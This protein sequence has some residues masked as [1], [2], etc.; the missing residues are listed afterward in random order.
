M[1]LLI[2]VIMNL[3][4]INIT[5]ASAALDL[6]LTGKINDYTSNLFLRIDSNAGSGIDV[7]DMY[8]RET[9]S[10]YSSFSSSVAG[11]SLSIDS[12]ASNPR[13]LNLT[14]SVSPAQTGTFNLSWNSSAINTGSYVVTLKYYGDNSTYTTQVG[15]NVDMSAQ[16]SYT[17]DITGESD[18]YVRIIVEDY[19][20]PTA[21]PVSP[22]GGGGGAAPAVAGK[23]FEILSDKKM[24][25]YMVIDQNKEQTIVLKNPTNKTVKLTI[26]PEG[27]DF[28][29][30]IV[31]VEL[32][33]GE[34][35]NVK[36]KILAFE[37]P[38]IYTGKINVGG[39]EILITVNVNTKEFLFDVSVTI[40]NGF[41]IVGGGEKLQ[42][43][44]TLIPM[45]EGQRLD[46]TLNYLIKDFSGRTFLTESETL[47]VEGQK[48][49]KKSFST[50]N[51]PLGNYILGLE[52]IYPNGVATSSSYFEV[53]EKEPS[54]LF[55]LSNYK[56][57]ALIFGIGISV[58]IL[59]II[60][61]IIISKRKIKLRKR[62]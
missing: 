15:S 42:S 58:L 28:V 34:T 46:V 8:S 3:A 33:P 2:L 9:P 12:W 51:L 39:E 25:A 6:K 37:K 56:I 1:V 57:I 48:T 4:V 20:A 55:T 52:L 22:G 29:N 24:T 47:L 17:Q 44:I 14:Y 11:S 26:K 54:A 35:K 7:Y 18:I 13:T 62:K 40:P 36:F 23:D 53:K 45:V 59:F 50:Q 32:A 41:K 21:T 31:D 61:S 30:E 16:N 49:F 60:I 5:T 38:G 43:Q 19:V 27:I 10:N